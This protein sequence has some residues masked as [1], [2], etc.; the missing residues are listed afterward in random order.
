MSDHDHQ[1]SSSSGPSIV[2]PD[3]WLPFMHEADLTRMCLSTGLNL[4][5]NANHMATGL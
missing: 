1:E 3:G 4:L 5:S 2:L